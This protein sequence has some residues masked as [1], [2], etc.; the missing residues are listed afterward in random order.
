MPREGGRLDSVVDTQSSGR[1][2]FGSVIWLQD[3]RGQRF[4]SLSAR[5]HDNGDT[6]DGAAATATH[7]RTSSTRPC[8]ESVF[9]AQ[10]LHCPFCGEGLHS[11]GQA[12]AVHVECADLPS[13]F[14]PS[15]CKNE[16]CRR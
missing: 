14:E 15:L 1:W 10:F 12:S 9:P 8:S 11:G 7:V 4:I 5:A 6:D 2:Q 3:T 16:A 13:I